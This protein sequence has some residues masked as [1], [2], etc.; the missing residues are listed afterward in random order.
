VTAVLQD[1]DHGLIRGLGIGEG[2]AAAAVAVDVHQSWQEVTSLGCGLRL[3]DDVS[4]AGPGGL[5]S[6]PDPR[7]VGSGQDDRPVVDDVVGGDD[8]TLKCAD[9]HGFVAHES[10]SV[11]TPD[12][13][14]HRSG[15]LLTHTAR[16]RPV[17]V[18]SSGQAVLHT[19]DGPVDIALHTGRWRRPVL[20]Q[21]ALADRTHGDE[22]A[23]VHQDRAEHA[24]A[25]RADEALAGVVGQAGAVLVAHVQLVEGAQE[26]R[27]LRGA[28][29]EAKMQNVAA[30]EQCFTMRG[31]DIAGKKEKPT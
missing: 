12:V 22:T 20:P 31:D 29:A 11:T 25:R 8:A 17:P 23:A 27:G 3:L 1:G 6:G 14:Q 4:E 16:R 13:R 7:D 18:R 21:Q 19:G 9:L 30:L 24:V 26:V 15:R 28:A 5:V 2:L 10:D